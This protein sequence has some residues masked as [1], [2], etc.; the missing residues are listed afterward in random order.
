MAPTLPKLLMEATV[1]GASLLA[2]VAVLFMATPRWVPAPLVVFLAGFLFHLL[3]EW[4]GVN[5]WYCS[6]Y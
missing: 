6:Q 3:A 2:L 1:V 4:A 5:G